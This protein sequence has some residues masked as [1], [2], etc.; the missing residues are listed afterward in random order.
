MNLQLT[1]RIYQYPSQLEHHF[2]DYC[3]VDKTEK[4]AEDG[5]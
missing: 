3:K 2:S 5:C 1:L 4:I